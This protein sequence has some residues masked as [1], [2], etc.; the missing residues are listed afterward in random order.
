MSSKLFRHDVALFFILTLLF[1]ATVWII[2]LPSIQHDLHISL[3]ANFFWL[4]EAA[5]GLVAIL[6][7]L[8]QD[9]KTGVK[10][11]LRP[12]LYWRIKPLYLYIIFIC[13]P[14]Y[15]LAL[16][17]YS[18]IFGAHITKFTTLYAQIKTPILHLPAIWLLLELSVIYLV[19]EEIGWRGFALKKLLNKYNPLYAA[20]IIGIFWALFHMP[21]LISNWAHVT[22][23]Y[24]LFYI[25]FTIIDSIFFA[26]LYI[27]TRYSLI[28]V[29]IIHGLTNLLGTFAPSILSP[30]GQGEDYPFIIMRLIIIVPCLIYL[31]KKRGG[32]L[33]KPGAC[34]N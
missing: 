6:L 5:P 26:W 21:L 29:G 24:L 34:Q 10:E 33:S 16:I 4:G 18:A 25:L 20:F 14:F 23:N 30:V 19:C 1:S 17:G 8:L 7:S 31:L 27:E 28:Y 3:S 32:G 2:L 12:I 9:G 13:I 11:L 22:T 15:Y